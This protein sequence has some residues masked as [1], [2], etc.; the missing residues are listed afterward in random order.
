VSSVKGTTFRGI[1]IL[2]GRGTKMFGAL[3][4]FNKKILPLRDVTSDVQTSLR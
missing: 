2:F 1:E 4:G 3:E